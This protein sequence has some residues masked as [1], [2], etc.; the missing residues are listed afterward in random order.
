MRESKVEAY[1]VKRV[2]DTGGI[3]RKT[4]YVGRMGCP[5]RWCGWPS[6]QRF[7]WVELKGDGGMLSGHQLREIPRL[8]ATGARVDVLASIDEVDAYVEEMSK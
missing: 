7:G 2:A 3:T 6:S 1:F 8:R 4:Q 5:D